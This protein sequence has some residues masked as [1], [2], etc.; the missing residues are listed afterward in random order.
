M[1]KERDVH[2]VE[3]NKGDVY[4]SYSNEVDK[5]LGSISDCLFGL[6]ID[7]ED[8]EGSVH[9]G[10]NFFGYVYQCFNNGRQK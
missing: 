6:D 2:Y 5:I 3:R 4:Y 8:L 1:R 7:V 9:I 10:A